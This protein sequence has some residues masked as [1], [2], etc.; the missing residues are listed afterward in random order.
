MHSKPYTIEQREK[1]KSFL[2]ICEGSNTEPAY[3]KSFP[4][5]NA[6][7]EC[8]GMGSSKTALVEQVIDI[9][10]KDEDTKLKEVWVVFDF[11]I[12]PDQLGQQKMDYN[13]AII[14]AE[15][16][17][18]K[19][20]CSNDCFEL[21][22]LL[23]YQPVTN[24][25][26]RHQYYEKLS[27]LWHCNYQKDGKAYTFCRNIYQR[28]QKDERCSQDE[29]ILRAQSLHKEHFDRPHADKNPFT[30]VFQLVQALNA[31]L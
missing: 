14:L 2:I 12:R 30:S 7:V 6:E 24:Q 28:L 13:E 11:D 17:D 9:L 27:E 18:I 16:N 19:V 29:A 26:I 8:Y 25:W 23:H 21:W 31:Y 5:G 10:K 20:A 4:L 22:F 15:H 3:F 1:A